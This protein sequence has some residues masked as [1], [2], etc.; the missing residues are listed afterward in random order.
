MERLKS[1]AFLTAINELRGMGALSNAE[2]QTATAAIAALDPYGTEE[3]FL[4]RLEEYER[5]VKLGRDRAA[6]RT[7]APEGAAAP[8]APAATPT[9]DGGWKTLPSGIKIRVKP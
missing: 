7:K 1:G 6:K 3:G 5:I 8:E 9:A 2:G 4:K